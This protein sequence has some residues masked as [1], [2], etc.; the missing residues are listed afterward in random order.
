M[1]E[2]K[3]KYDIA[4]SFLAEDEPLAVVLADLLQNRVNIF[5]YSKKQSDIA[6]TDGELTFNK[7]FAELSRLVVVLYRKG[8]G[9]S[10]W[11]RI[12]ETAIRNRAYNYGYDFVKFIPLD[13][14]P[15]VPSSLCVNKV[16]AFFYAI[17]KLFKLSFVSLLGFKNISSVESQTLIFLPQRSG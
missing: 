1:D 9:E 7:V 4:F 15:N 10:P 6:G 17:F 2:K 3:Y 16:V 11:T 13:D 12:E 8:W 5:L 14:P